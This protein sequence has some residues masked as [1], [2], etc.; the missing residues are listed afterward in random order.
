M[1]DRDIIDKKE[2]VK[3][4]LSHLDEVIEIERSS[5]SDPWS[6]RMFVSE[7]KS[8]HTIYFVALSDNKVIG[9]VGGWI[10]LNELHITN[11][12]VA[13]THRGRGIANILLDKLFVVA[14][15]R[16]CDIAYLEVRA[17]NTPAQNLYNKLGFEVAYVRKGY[18]TKP[19][20]DALVMVKRLRG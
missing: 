17:S 20:E 18:Y 5:F 11:L 8:P 9:Y 10:V 12:A 15:E 16:G 2:I 1:T 6:Y 3:M 4:E 14:I 19:I 13:G 7:L